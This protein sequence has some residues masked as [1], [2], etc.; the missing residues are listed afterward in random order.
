LELSVSEPALSQIL[1]GAKET[2]LTLEEDLFQ[3]NE[4]PKGLEGRYTAN[5][6]PGAELLTKEEL[7]VS[8]HLTYKIGKLQLKLSM[9]LIY[10]YVQ[11]SAFYLISS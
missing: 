9:L 1:Q 3:Q 4:K 6:I 8:Q 5:F 2:S 7:E 11:K 10:S